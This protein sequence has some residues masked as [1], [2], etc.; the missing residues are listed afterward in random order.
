M[1][2]WPMKLI[3]AAIRINGKTRT[4]PESE[5]APDSL[6]DAAQVTADTTCAVAPIHSTSPP[7]AGPESTPSDTVNPPNTQPKI[8]TCRR[9]MLRWRTKAIAAVVRKRSLTGKPHTQSSIL[10][11]HPLD[12]HIGSAVL[13]SGLVA[14]A[15]LHAVS[16]L[17]AAIECAPDNDVDLSQARSALRVLAELGDGVAGVPWLK[18]AAGL[19]LE[20]VNTLDTVQSNKSDCRDLALRICKFLIL[21][22]RNDASAAQHI[23]DFRRDLHRILRTVKI[24]SS[25]KHSRRLFKADD[26]REQIYKCNQMLDQSRDVFLVSAHMELALEA[27]KHIEIAKIP[28]RANFG[29][30]LKISPAVMTLFFLIDHVLYEERDAQ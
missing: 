25:Y 12:R 22:H 8:S 6:R 27:A 28:S 30:A 23:N 10:P 4:T 1:P 3:A 11:V 7:P 16:P 17:A 19:G 9:V 26:I 24:I 18:G 5:A 14:T 2:R 21:M 15:P 20:I 13:V 29:P